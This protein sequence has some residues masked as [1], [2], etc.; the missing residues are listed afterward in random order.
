MSKVNKMGFVIMLVSLF[1]M[2]TLTIFFG[3]GKE[4]ICTL[5]IIILGYYLYEFKPKKKMSKEEFKPQYLAALSMLCGKPT[6]TTSPFKGEFKPKKGV[7]ERYS[8]I[9]NQN[10]D[11]KI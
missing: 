10:K 8:Q 1:T 3:N 9:L 6:Y 4:V 2:L 7:K 11:E 5:P